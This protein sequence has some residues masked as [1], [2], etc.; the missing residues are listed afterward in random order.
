MG[1]S[2][3]IIVIVV[4]VVGLIIAGVFVINHFQKDTKINT[5]N[6]K[7]SQIS[8]KELQEKIIKRLENNERVN[9]KSS[10]VKTT[11][12]TQSMI[13][14]DSLDFDMTFFKEKNHIDNNE[15]IVFAFY[16]NN[17]ET[18]NDKCHI[19][20][21]LFEI[22]KKEN[23]E[24]KRILFNYSSYEWYE[25]EVANIIKD[26]LQIDYDIDTESLRLGNS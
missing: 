14:S 2:I 19:A 13:Q 11:I 9:I 23:G 24:F 15:N 26:I 20:I 22:K 21:P 18:I 3:K 16:E 5:I 25:E 6:E 12:G 4:L 17:E 1:K 8:S 7:I 10:Y